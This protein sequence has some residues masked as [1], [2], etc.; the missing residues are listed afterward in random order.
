MEI[1]AAT[2]G[3]LS[4]ASADEGSGTLIEL[5][6]PLTRNGGKP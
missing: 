2:I 1:R 5:D 6:I 3:A 4:V